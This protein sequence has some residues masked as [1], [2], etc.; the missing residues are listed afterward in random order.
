MSTKYKIKSVDIVRQVKPTAT[1]SFLGRRIFVDT[2]LE[3][4]VEPLRGQGYQSEVESFYVRVA[5]CHRRG[6]VLSAFEQKISGENWKS[7]LVGALAAA[8]EA[9]E[10]HKKTQDEKFS[11]TVKAG[12][13]RLDYA[14]KLTEL[15]GAKVSHWNV[16]HGADG[17]PT[18]LK[19]EVFVTG[20]PEKVA[21]K[22]LQIKSISA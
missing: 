1:T 16:T 9:G 13:A 20:T 8:R 11:H 15:L 12:Q 4:S 6:R 21:Q 3:I 17:F 19:L 18:G 14:N 7:Q 10:R 22:I 2:N 5:S